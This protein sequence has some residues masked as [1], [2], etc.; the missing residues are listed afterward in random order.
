[1]SL[2]YE[3]GFRG[4]RC[5][6]CKLAQLKYKLGD[7]FYFLNGSIYELD[8]EPHPGQEINEH[9]GHSLRFRMWAPSYYHSDECY[10]WQP[11]EGKSKSGA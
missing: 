6:G 9:M 2:A 10:N 8:V 11:P 7:K 4:P 3:M 1:M 5:N